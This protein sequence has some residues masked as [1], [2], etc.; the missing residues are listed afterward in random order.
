VVSAGGNGPAPER[1]TTTTHAANATIAPPAV[2]KLG[3]R[4]LETPGALDTFAR[5]AAE[6]GAPR[7]LV[8]G[9]GSEVS[10]WC[11]RLG[12]EPHFL[13]GLRV[14]DDATLEVATAVLAGLA[15]KRLVAAL[16]AAGADAVGLAALDGDTVQVTLHPAHTRLGRVGAVTGVDTALLDT[17]VATG[18]LP[19]LASIGAADGALL[20]LNADDVAAALAAA[21]GGPL[22]LLSDTPGLSIAGEIVPRLHTGVMDTLMKH[23]D[24]QGGMRPK[25]HAARHAVDHGAPFARIAQWSPGVTLRELLGTDG[26]GTTLVPDPVSHPGKLPQPVGGR[27]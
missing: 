8:H 27:S 7:V 19:V 4:A 20:N 22:L 14:T 25:L 23:P 10:A 2:I 13:D 18:R 12:V 6:P 21:L 3:G 17:L 1:V 5:A 15:N 24:I 9:G 11:A 26:P 16:R